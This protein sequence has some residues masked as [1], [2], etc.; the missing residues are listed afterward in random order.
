MPK[1]IQVFDTGGI[2]EKSNIGETTKAC[3]QCQFL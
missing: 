2:D 1:E 3:P